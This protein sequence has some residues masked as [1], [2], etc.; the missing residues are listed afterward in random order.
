M[1]IGSFQAIAHRLADSA[2]A[3]DGARLLAH[4]A[5]W[6]ADDD[7][8]RGRRAG[9]PGLRLRGRDRPRRVGYRS[10]HFHGGY[11]FMME[12]DIQLLLAAGPG[13]DRAS[14]ASP[15]RPTGGP[16]DARLPAEGR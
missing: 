9:R 5:A 7:P 4:E 1:P 12:Y 8:D 3:V 14:G 10:L 2:A 6:A 15:A 13:V 11:G 16:T